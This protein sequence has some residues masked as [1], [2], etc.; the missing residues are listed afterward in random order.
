MADRLHVCLPTTGTLEQRDFGKDI[1]AVVSNSPNSF[2]GGL[3]FAQAFKKNTTRAN[4]AEASE[5]K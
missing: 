3:R 4:D 2:L 5:G 1:L